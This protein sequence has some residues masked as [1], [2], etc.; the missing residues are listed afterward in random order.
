LLAFA[1]GKILEA[2]YIQPA[3]TFLYLLL[4][5]IAVLTLS[6]AVLGVHFRFLSDLQ[7]RTKAWHIVLLLLLIVLA[8]W[9]VTFTRAMMER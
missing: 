9:A 3:A 7:N 6:A 8:G 1:Q 4:C 5:A 2:F